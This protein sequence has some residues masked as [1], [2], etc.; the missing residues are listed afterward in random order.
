MFIKK[1]YEVNPIGTNRNDIVL[2]TVFAYITFFRLEELSIEDY[3]KLVKAAK[4]E[5]MHSF[6]Q[7]C[8]DTDALRNA[9]LREMWMELYDYQY[10]DDKILGGIDKNL[11][12]VAHII[13]TVEKQA[14]GKI[15]SNL[16]Q[17]AA[18]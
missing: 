2:Y 12:N 17:S 7:F 9:G 14:T 15:T 11:P 4:Y 13:Q 6:M 1:L 18:S 5:K 10:I 16:S 3:R 8:F